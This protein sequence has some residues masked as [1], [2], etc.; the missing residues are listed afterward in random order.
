MKL[1]IAILFAAAVVCH[2]QPVPQLRGPV[3][4]GA[5]VVIY[6]RCTVDGD[7][8]LTSPIN[9]NWSG[10]WAWRQELSGFAFA[11]T[12]QRIVLPGPGIYR[13]AVC[14]RTDYE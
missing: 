3:R 7:Y 9:G 13:V 5:E 6:A 14:P 12:E 2:A 4:E 1:A 8:F 10:H 11:G